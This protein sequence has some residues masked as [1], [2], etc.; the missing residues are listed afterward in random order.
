MSASPPRTVPKPLRLGARRSQEDADAVHAPSWDSSAAPAASVP[1]VD[2]TSPTPNT[3]DDAVL[4]PV[5]RAA[6]DSAGDDAESPGKRRFRGGAPDRGPVVEDAAD[7]RPV[8]P[9]AQALPL[10]VRLPKVAKV[11]PVPVPVPAPP[12]DD[13]EAAIRAL[14]V[15]G[16]IETQPVEHVASEFSGGVRVSV[17]HSPQRLNLL[18]LPL[19]S[20]TFQSAFAPPKRPT[21]SLKLQR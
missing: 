20:S 11:V 7:E 12:S 14:H 3:L 9:P 15:V 21:Q 13:F 4:Q 16:G 17:T 2:S 8:T 1:I 6:S 18:F 10:P 5:P 19:P